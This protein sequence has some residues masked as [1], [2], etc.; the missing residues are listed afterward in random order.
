MGLIIL[1]VAVLCTYGAKISDQF[2]LRSNYIE[3]DQVNSL[4]GIF[5]LIIFISHSRGYMILDGSLDALFDF[6]PVFLGQ[7]MVIPFLFYSGY[8]VMESIKAKG[9]A[10]VSS[11]LF[12]RAGKVWIHFIFVV[13][14]YCI[15]NIVFSVH[16]DW[17][18]ILL[19]FFAWTSIGNSCWFIF[20]IIVLYLLNWL[21]FSVFKEKIKIASMVLFIGT[22]CL[23]LVL[24]YGFERPYYWYD[25]L[26]F[27]PIG[28]IY[29]LSRK[30]LDCILK[31]KKIWI[32]GLT[33]IIVV[34][35][36]FKTYCGFMFSA[37]P[38]GSFFFCEIYYLLFLMIIVLVTMRVKIGNSVL[39]FFGKHIF[40]IYMLQNISFR[41]LTE[42]GITEKYVFFF[43]AL[44]ITVMLSV[45]FDV[46]M[47]K[48]D[49]VVFRPS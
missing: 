29:S 27:Y 8:G 3:K 9:N 40:S 23:I 20:A 47:N 33:S 13:L 11:F 37:L 49:R 18:T 4:K 46:L 7:M 42:I 39:E 6:I 17:K 16:F 31:D 10:Y 45:L 48:F 25:T 15:V 41:I 14:L 36:L 24:C 38:M 43:I 12:Q 26:I 44:M 28:T 35:L 1:I 2:V 22:I 5:V 19:A 34:F 21:V 30:R 32:I